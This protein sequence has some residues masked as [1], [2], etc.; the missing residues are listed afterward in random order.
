MSWEVAALI[1]CAAAVAVAV[2][3]RNQIAVLVAAGAYAAVIGWIIRDDL[4]L[5]MPALG[6][7][8]AL[9]VLGLAVVLGQEQEDWGEGLPPCRQRRRSDAGGERSL[10]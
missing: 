3:R 8:I 6:L 9:A 5:L 2:L 7:A 4:S 1:G 10:R